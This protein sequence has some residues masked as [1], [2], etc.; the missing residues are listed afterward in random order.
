MLAGSYDNFC[1]SLVL[2][3]LWRILV[4]FYVCLFQSLG[5]WERSPENAGRRRAGYLS[6]F[7]TKPRSLPAHFSIVLTYQGSGIVKFVENMNSHK[8]F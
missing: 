3:M 6:F 7:S 5:Q 2:S 1:I 8:R 4:I